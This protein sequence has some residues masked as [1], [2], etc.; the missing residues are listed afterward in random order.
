MRKVTVAF[1]VALSL[2]AIGTLVLLQQKSRQLR[3]RDELLQQQGE[4]IAQL[5]SDNERLS[6]TLVKATT[7]DSSAQASELLKLRGE[8]GLLRRQTSEVAK[9]REENRRLQSASTARQPAPMPPYPTDEQARQIGI[10]KLSDA[11][12]LMLGFVLFAQANQ[13]Q[14][15]ST[16][17]QAKPFLT[18]ADWSLTQTNQF[19]ILYQ[20]SLTDL[21][22]PQNIIVL[23]EQQA[24]PAQQGGW[25]R[26]YGF[27]DGHSEI[28]H[29][30]DGNFQDWEAQHILAPPAAA[31]PGR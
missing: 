28:H 2:L 6:N 5:A 4:Q 15:P 26:T 23:R 24:W 19:E 29:S 21:T 7:P 10:A 8:L 1:A 9:L 25:S 27:A 18:N 22:S 12:V 16:L 11:K 3:E 13:T 30:A 20:G 14:F 31:Q 17:D